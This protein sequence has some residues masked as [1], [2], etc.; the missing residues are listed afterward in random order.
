MIFGQK[1]QEVV[2]NSPDQIPLF[3]YELLRDDVLPELLGKEYQSILYWAGKT[4]ARKYPLSSIEEI[5]AFF[6]K[7]GWGELLLIKE[8]NDE[9]LFE[10]TSPLFEQK[11]ILSTPLEAGFLAQQIQY[12]KEFITETNETVKN[13]RATKIVY[14]VKWDTHDR[15]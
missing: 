2:N 14:R 15:V 7:A 6:T 3:G 10:L 5:I 13:G 9:A 8:K 11:K 4:L 12:I 1:K